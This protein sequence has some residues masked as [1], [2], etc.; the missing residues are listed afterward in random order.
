MRLT[1]A[2]GQRSVII[3]MLKAMRIR[4]ARCLLR[5]LSLLTIV[6]LL[7]TPNC[8]PLCAGQ[9]CKRADASATAN[10]S[11]HRAGTVHHYAL[12]VYGIRNCNLS[13]SPA[14]VSTSATLSGI[15]GESRLGVPG[16]QFLADERENS[17]PT[18][19][20]SDSWFCRPHGFSNGFTPVSSGV[21]RI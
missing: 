21:L 2:D 5:A 17:L 19:P 9:N 12:F 6:A 13:E 16:E 14:I 3:R 11:C 1:Q 10:E 20:F 4:I 18:A 15:S 7:V 8:G